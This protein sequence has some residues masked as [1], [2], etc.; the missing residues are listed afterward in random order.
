[1]QSQIFEA[2]FSTK[3]DGVG[4]GL[5]ISKSLVGQHGGQIYLD[6]SDAHGTEFVIILPE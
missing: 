4:L 3:P 5:A 1:M 6:H 2:F